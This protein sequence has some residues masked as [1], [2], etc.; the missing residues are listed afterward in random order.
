MNYLQF[1]QKFGLLI[2]FAAVFAPCNLNAQEAP[3]K[4]TLDE[5]RGTCSELISYMKNYMKEKAPGLSDYAKRGTEESKDGGA[6]VGEGG[7]TIVGLDRQ[8]HFNAIQVKNK[9]GD[10]GVCLQMTELDQKVFRSTTSMHRIDWK[11]NWPEESQC[12]K[13]WTRVANLIETHER[14]HVRHAEEI[15]RQMRGKLIQ[16][17]QDEFLTGKNRAVFCGDSIKSAQEKMEKSMGKV[18]LA[19]EEE[20]NSKYREKAKEFHISDP[21]IN[22]DCSKC[23]SYSFEG[24]NIHWK[25]Q[26]TTEIGPKVTAIQDIYIES[27]GKICGNPLETDLGY[28]DRKSPGWEAR[29][30]WSIFRALHFDPIG[31]KTYPF[32]FPRFLTTN[33]PQF[34]WIVPPP[35]NYMP[36][37]YAMDISLQNIPATPTARVPAIVSEEP[38]GC[39]E[40]QP[41]LKPVSSVPQATKWST[42]FTTVPTTRFLRCD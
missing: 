30:P 14:T 42:R 5:F 10:T 29:V 21:K 12:A 28:V 15:A 41:G 26:T 35:L 7:F 8:I 3:A 33:P 37:N 32:G 20:F 4:F 2:T 13:E 24:L 22:L 1:L 9:P 17:I 27:S 23:K 39:E 6:D 34:E 31:A 25:V 40:S 38:R 36:P 19:A 11:H 16:N 18:L